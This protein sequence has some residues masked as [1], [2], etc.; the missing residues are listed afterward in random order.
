M[1]IAKK[2]ES[3]IKDLDKL[4]VEKCDS[5]RSLMSLCH[6]E[7]IFPEQHID[8]SGLW[9]S[10]NHTKFNESELYNSAHLLQSLIQTEERLISGIANVN[11]PFLSSGNDTGVSGSRNDSNSSTNSLPWETISFI[12]DSWEHLNETDNQTR[13]FIE[14][15]WKKLNESEFRTPS[16]SIPMREK[17]SVLPSP[18]QVVEKSSL[19]AKLNVKRQIG[20]IASSLLGLARSGVMRG[21]LFNLVGPVLKN[22]VSGGHKHEVKQVAEYIIP[23]TGLK[24]QEAAQNVHQLLHEGNVTHAIKTL[25][26]DTAN[27]RPHNL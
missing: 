4:S 21:F 5:F 25:K 16:F 18:S 7:N 9:Q 11:I 8:L 15:A 23:Y 13:S 10:A 27:F 24:D 1:E 17:R 12:Q 2:E 6:S 3:L 22:L 20:A 14:A 19:P 26:N